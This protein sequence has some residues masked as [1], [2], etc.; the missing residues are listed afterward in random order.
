MAASMGHWW[1]QLQRCLLSRQEEGGL[2]TQSPH[3]ACGFKKSPFPQ[4]GLLGWE[5]PGQQ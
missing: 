1:E 2:T 3:A 4:A 5:R